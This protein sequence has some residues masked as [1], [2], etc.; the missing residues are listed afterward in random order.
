MA[1]C[2]STTLK[3]L[4]YKNYKKKIKGQG[5]IHLFT[6]IVWFSVNFTTCILNYGQTMLC[7]DRTQNMK[8][9]NTTKMSVHTQQRAVI[10]TN[11]FC[12]FKSSGVYERIRSFVR[13]AT[14]YNIGNAGMLAQVC[15]FQSPH[16]NAI[17]ELTGFTYDTA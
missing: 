13:A 12:F 3:Y 15:L 1:L 11:L 8:I 10:K 6:M 17:V 2:E 4:L 16:R 5:Q 7:S 9:V 14:A